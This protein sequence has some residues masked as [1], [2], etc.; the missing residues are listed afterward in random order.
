MWFALRIYDAP[1]PSRSLRFFHWIEPSMAKIPRPPKPPITTLRADQHTTSDVS[2]THEK[3]IGR[4]LSSWSRLEQEMENLIWHF[5]EL[6]VEY[7]RTITAKMDTNSRIQL[8]RLLA[9][10]EFEKDELEELNGILTQIDIVREDRNFIMHGVWGTIAPEGIPIAYSLR[11]NHDPGEI[12]GETFPRTRMLALIALIRHLTGVMDRWQIR[13]TR[14]RRLPP[15]PTSEPS[16]TC[17]PN[18]EG[19][20]SATP[21]Q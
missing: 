15:R 17:E 6:R 16:P 3:L 4:L 14:Q 19:S 13:L 7:G 18:P 12:V 10:L 9:K 5:L 2:L 8:L 11:P 20:L 1:T 21:S